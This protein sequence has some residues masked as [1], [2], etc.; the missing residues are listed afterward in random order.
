MRYPV[1]LDWGHFAVTGD[2]E[3]GVVI[4]ALALALCQCLKQ[5][6]GY[7]RVVGVW[8]VIDIGA[9]RPRAVIVEIAMF[10]RQPV[11][12]GVSAQA[13]QRGVE[14]AELNA[15][16]GIGQPEMLFERLAFGRVLALLADPVLQQVFIGELQQG[17]AVAREVKQRQ[18]ALDVVDVEQVG[19]CIAIDTQCAQA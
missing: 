1:H 15:L 11:A 18:S 2:D 13:L 12:E 7:E 8:P 10:R 3:I 6:T 14:A 17:S 16:G 5:V 4:G 9:R 19:G